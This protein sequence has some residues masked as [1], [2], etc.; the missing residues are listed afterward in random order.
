MEI[1]RKLAMLRDKRMLPLVDA[2]NVSA[3]GCATPDDALTVIPSVT[4]SAALKSPQLPS[5]K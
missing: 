4:S 1:G 3:G 5:S 2:T